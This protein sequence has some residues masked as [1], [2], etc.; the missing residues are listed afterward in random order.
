MKK[1]IFIILSIMLLSGFATAQDDPMERVGFRGWGPRLGATIDPDQVH[2]GAHIDFGNFARHIRLQ[3]NFE[4][5]IGDDVILA[6]ANLE[7]HYRFSANWDVWTPYLGG[8]LGINIYNFDSDN[9][10]VGNGNDEIDD[11]Q[12]ELGLN[13]VGGIEKGLS[14]GDRFFLELKIGFADSPDFKITAGWTFFH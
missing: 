13:A 8:G 9:N 6:A 2:F 5:G 11:T 14:N 10:G 7:G 3:P 12:T 1:L 4:L